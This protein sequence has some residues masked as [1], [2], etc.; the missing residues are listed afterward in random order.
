MI[1]GEAASSNLDLTVDC[2]EHEIDCSVNVW[3]MMANE[4]QV[5]IEDDLHLIEIGQYA[6]SEYL[7]LI[8][9]Y[10]LMFA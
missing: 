8:Y 1:L 2:Y 9:K 3:K 10:F 7:A 5:K 4:D 6:Y